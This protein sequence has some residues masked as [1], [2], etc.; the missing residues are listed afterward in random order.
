MNLEILKELGL[1][2]TEIKIY[3]SLLQLGPS[4]ASKISQHSKVERAVTYHTLEKLI[5]KGI[6]SYVIRENRK[7]FSAAEPEKLKALM[8]EKEDLL[9]NLIPELKK[10][11]KPQD[12]PL[13]IE[14]FRGI[15]GYK[16]VMEDLIN[17]KK[18]YCIIGYAGKG[19]MISKFWYMHYQKRRIKRKIPRYL[20]IHHNKK[21]IESLKYPLTKTRVLPETIIYEPKSSTIIYGKDKVLLFLPLQEFAGIII[22]NKETH[23]SY[24][25]YFNILW[26]ISKYHK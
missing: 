8:I 16:T 23:N 2:N 18:P 9:N 4:L 14:V 13:S 11:E 7:Y 3:I 6:A 19:A 24:Q 22:K 17:E 25:E 20:L 10:L 12:Q 26:N 1:T 5:R 21:N 15:E